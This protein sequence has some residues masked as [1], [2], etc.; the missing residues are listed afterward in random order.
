MTATFRYQCPSCG[1][2]SNSIRCPACGADTDELALEETES[3]GSYT[4]FD[5]A[6]LGHTEG[7]AW[8]HNSEKVLVV[9][10]ATKREWWQ[11]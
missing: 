2:K 11:T 4:I 6:Q 3:G 10:P 8:R 5:H 9:S 1:A 7:V